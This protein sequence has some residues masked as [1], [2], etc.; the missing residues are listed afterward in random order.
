M[1]QRTC[2]CMHIGRN[3]IKGQGRLI[4]A[5]F[6]HPPSFSWQQR[7]A[8]FFQPHH[9]PLTPS[10]DL[11]WYRVV[12][13]SQGHCSARYVVRS[14][15]KSLLI[16][17]SHFHFP[18]RPGTANAALPRHVSDPGTGV[19]DLARLPVSREDL[20][21]SPHPLAVVPTSHHRPEL[22]RPGG[23]SVGAPN[24][25]MNPAH[26]PPVRRPHLSNIHR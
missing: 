14:N 22:Q 13:A 20:F 12:T 24:G 16:I 3:Q 25:P 8:P 7:G 4:T 11:V 6:P 9:C 1:V 15:N 5:I 21:I 23:G 19:I 2:T 26:E 18:V 10:N 17:L